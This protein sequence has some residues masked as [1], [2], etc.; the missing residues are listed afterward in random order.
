MKKFKRTE[1][2]LVG[3]DA[4]FA[5]MGFRGDNEEVAGFDID[6]AREVARRWGVEVEFKPCEWD[7]ILSI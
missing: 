5:P 7:G 1:N 2:L 3:L 4:T 6:L